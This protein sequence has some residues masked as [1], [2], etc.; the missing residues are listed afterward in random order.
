MLLPVTI[1]IPAYN[2]EKFIARVLYC[3]LAQP[4]AQIIVSDNGS[5]DNTLKICEEFAAQHPRV[6]I[7][8]QDENKGP[9][10]NFCACIKSA[11]TRFF[12]FLGAHDI[13]SAQ[14][15]LSLM[16]ALGKTPGAVGAYADA[17]YVDASDKV[18]G[19]YEYFYAA[20]LLSDSALERVMAL[21][22][23]LGDG[24]I[25]HGLYDR[26]LYTQA[27]TD[28]HIIPC[29]FFYVGHMAIHGKLVRAPGI[30]YCRYTNGVETAE[31]KMDRYIS[32]F[33]K[34]DPY[35]ATV[36]NITQRQ[37]LTVLRHMLLIDKMYPETR[38]RKQ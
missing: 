24:T 17:I 12:M 23:H 37:N 36:E 35:F 26:E 10:H 27:W 13:I 32:F 28:P 9:L 19:S 33:G 3:A 29:D 34:V 11:T 2:E 31:Q 4:V 30:S 38:Y 8:R 20:K 1:G 6:I 5:T 25:V 21:T 22:H 18:I 7:L 15:T 14:H 16:E